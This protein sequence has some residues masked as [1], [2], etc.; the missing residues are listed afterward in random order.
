V[1][2]ITRIEW[3]RLPASTDTASQAIELLHRERSTAD[4]TPEWSAAQDVA[5]PNEFFEMSLGQR[6]SLPLNVDFSP[7]PFFPDRRSDPR[8]GT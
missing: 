4:G 7:L 2:W 1:D 3:A 5:L 6:P 8:S